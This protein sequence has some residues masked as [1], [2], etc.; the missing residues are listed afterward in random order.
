VI[1]RNGYLVSERYFNGFDKNDFHNI[2]SVS[3]SFLSALLGIA[4]H[5][6]YIPDLDVKIMDY[7]P[8]YVNADSRFRQ[9]T[10]RHLITMHSG[11]DNDHNNFGPIF[12]SDDWLGAT[13]NQTLIANPGEEFHYTTAGT[14]LLSAILTKSSGMSSYDFAQ[15]YLFNPLNISLGLWEKGPRGYYFGGSD[16]HTS[17]RNM[18]KFGQ[19]YMNNGM[20]NDVRIVPS[21]WVTSSIQDRMLREDLTWGPLTNMGYGYLWW[22][23]T[24]SGYKAF[25]ALGHGGQFIIA[26]P[27]LQMIVTT[28]S[29]S[30]YLDWDQADEQERAV[31][32]VV[33]EY[34]M[35]ALIE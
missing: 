29:Q 23:G 8:E 15:T 30:Y 18:A 24:I 28:V 22:L 4:I 14:H 12:Y 7:F 9:V 35:N 32:H 6:N 1:I 26:I 3:K 33:D 20:M 2:R 16:M 10:I 21:A 27:E 13:L 34:F 5:K 31:L 17:P 11:L 25:I 19:L